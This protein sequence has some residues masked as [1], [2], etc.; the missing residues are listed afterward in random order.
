MDMLNHMS[1]QTQDPP[2]FE[3]DAQTD[4]TPTSA[5]ESVGYA[6]LKEDLKNKNQHYYTSLLRNCN[7]FSLQNLNNLFDDVIYDMGRQS[8]NM[9]IEDFNQG[10]DVLTAL[11]SNPNLEVYTVM[12]DDNSI[13]QNR[14]LLMESAFRNRLHLTTPELVLNSSL[15]FTSMVFNKSILNQVDVTL[16][17]DHLSNAA[18]FRNEVTFSTNQIPQGFI[19]SPQSKNLLLKIQDTTLVFENAYTFVLKGNGEV[20][21]TENCNDDGLPSSGRYVR[22]FRNMIELSFEGCREGP[23]RKFIVIVN[24]EQNMLVP[25]IPL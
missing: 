8:Q 23:D 6:N 2:L 22:N 1:T 3:R 9:F 12:N 25:M 18:Y 21:V 16:L 11:I 14:D 15:T 19:Q 24:G 4:N 10:F 5:A 17:T 13:R 20:M 7:I